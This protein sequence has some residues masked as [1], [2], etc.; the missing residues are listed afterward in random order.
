[1][2]MA[3]AQ[4]KDAVSELE[5]TVSISGHRESV[6]DFVFGPD[7]TLYSLS[8]SMLAVWHWPSGAPREQFASNKAHKM[9]HDV[10]LDRMILWTQQGMVSVFDFT[11]RTV[12]KLVSPA[13][14]QSLLSGVSSAS[15]HP[16]IGL[17]SFA[18]RGGVS[19]FERQTLEP[20]DTISVSE[21]ERVGTSTPSA[22][23]P[24]LTLIIWTDSSGVI[25]SL[26]LPDADIEPELAAHRGASNSFMKL[27]VSADSS[28]FVSS[29]PTQVVV[30]DLKTG[31]ERNRVR[32]DTYDALQV[33]GIDESG[34][35]ILAGGR[36]LGVYDLN[37]K[38]MQ[39]VLRSGLSFVYRAKAKSDFS[40]FAA[41][42][43]KGR[44]VGWN[45][46]S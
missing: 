45:L 20:Y 29:D 16:G 6:S 31:K 22:I 43:D 25:N 1:M 33:H 10:E 34:S 41:A 15:I 40:A 46:A 39:V 12:Q 4:G 2:G 7:G 23:S 38:Q 24:D 27:S 37:K 30:W 3:F 5:S 32:T 18:H 36:P 8:R 21:M 44:I 42:D 13:R 11:K 28:T 35:R 14:P 19:L 17:Y 9:I 26:R